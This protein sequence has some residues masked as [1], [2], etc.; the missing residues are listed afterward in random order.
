MEE[1]DFRDKRDDRLVR[2][3]RDDYGSDGLPIVP[4]VIGGLA[5]IG[6]TAVII[7]VFP[8]IKRY[9]KISTM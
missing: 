7:A 3:R 9:I 1:R 5:L 4:M 2:Q 6:L 8:D